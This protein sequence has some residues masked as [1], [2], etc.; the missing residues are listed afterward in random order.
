MRL[1]AE[2]GD[3]ARRVGALERRQVDHADRELE[4]EELRLALDRA[5]RERRGALLERDR[6]DRADARQPR[7]ERELESGRQCGRLG[8]TTE[9][10]PRPEQRSTGER[11]LP[12]FLPVEAAARRAPRAGVAEQVLERPAVRRVRDQPTRAPSTRGPSS[13]KKRSQLRRTCG[14]S[15]TARGYGRRAGRGLDRV[16][17]RDRA[18]VQLA[19]VALASRAVRNGRRSRRRIVGDRRRRSRSSREHEPRDP[20][21]RL[22]S[23]ADLLDGVLERVDRV[24]RRGASPTAPRREADRRSGRAC[25][26]RRTARAAG[27]QMPRRSSIASSRRHFG[28]TFTCS[29]RK[30]GWPSSALDLGPGARADLLH[31][32]AALADDDLL[33]RLGLDEDRSRGRP[34]RPSSSTSTEIA[35]G[36]SSRVSCERLLADELGDLHLERAGR[37]AAR[38]GSTPAPRAAARRARRAARRRRRPS[39]RSRVER[40]EV[41]ELRRRSASASAMCPGFRRST[42]FSGDH[43]R[44]AEREDALR[45]E[46]VAG[47]DPLARVEHEE[48][49]RRRPR[50]TRRPCA[51]C[52]RSAR[53]AAAGS[54]AGRRARAGSP[55][56]FAI[57]KMRRRVVCGL[58][59]TI[60][61]L[62]PQSAFTSVDLPTFGRPATATNPLFKVPYPDPGWG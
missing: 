29:S 58:S 34:S 47:A 21:R 37:C 52:A 23:M 39:S 59:E 31:D 19:V 9:S 51:A 14:S 27:H 60:A 53:R 11:V 30:T 13:G 8:H 2:R 12:A 3:L 26:R 36:T 57:P 49:A 61:T 17:L 1:R 48:H 15:R 56:P 24:E 38:A 18:P 35:C 5:L 62:P 55:S 41:A 45:D 46:A 43:D 54:P 22:P 7:L 33:L 25:R 4:R 44:H 10:S 40:V 32:R 28:R 16:D 6:V 20:R 42:L 50:T